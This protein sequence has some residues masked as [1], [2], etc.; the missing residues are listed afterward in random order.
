M[1]EIKDRTC[2]QIINW[3]LSAIIHVGVIV[4]MLLFCDVQLISK[5]DDEL[6]L[7][8]ELLVMPV[9][10]Q[11]LPEPPSPP[12]PEPPKPEPPK[13]EPPKPEPPKPEPPKP[14]PPKPAPEPPKPAPVPE[15][16]KPQPIP[17]P[18]PVPEPPKPK[19]VPEPPKPTPPPKP[20]PLSIAERLKNAEVKHAKPAPSQS[21]QPR[22]TVKAASRQEIINRMNNAGKLSTTSTANVTSGLKSKFATPQE[23]SVNYA[24]NVVRPGYYNA[25]DTPR[26]GDRRPTPVIVELDVQSDGRVISAR[27]TRRSNDARMNESVQNLIRNVRQFTPFSQVGVRSSSLHIVVTLEIID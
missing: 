14:E 20:K 22:Q 6:E 1:N 24:D 9:V 3:L 19:P 5:P 25:W 16:P 17:K 11:T 8:S 4:L 23:E 15:P 26:I 10:Q 18:I 27:I 7:S 21:V 13:P 12:E 2:N